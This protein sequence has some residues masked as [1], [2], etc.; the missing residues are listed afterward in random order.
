MYLQY[1]VTCNVVGYYVWFLT[2]LFMYKRLMASFFLL[3]KKKTT[4]LAID[5][6]FVAP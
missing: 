1:N 6:A 4:H 2:H 5:K 3:I